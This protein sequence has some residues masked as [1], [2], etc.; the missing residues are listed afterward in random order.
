M[1]IISCINERRSI[2]SYKDEPIDEKTINKL[3]ELG[4]KAATG[5]AM[6][7]W[8]FVVIQDKEE[9]NKLSD[10]IKK[11]LIENFDKFPYLQKYKNWVENPKYNV[12]YDAGT[13]LI[14]YGNTD[15]H[16]NVY[17]CSLVAGNIMLGAY[18]MGIGSCWIG[19]GEYMLN[20][21]EFKKKYGVPENF[22]VVSP[23]TLGYMK[24][25]PKPPVRK[26]P[27]IFNKR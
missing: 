14:I 21:K 19:F 22:Q 5:S 6:E 18:E 27:I 25:K 24:I 1:S 9:I 13:L 10:E 23:L 20:T 26:A 11:Y 12:F 3:L 8:G 7:P 16:W 17:D 15:S 2:R 4:T